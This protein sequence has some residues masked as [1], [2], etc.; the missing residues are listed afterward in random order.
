MEIKTKVNTIKVQQKC[1]TCK[2]G[3]LISNGN[4]LPSNPSIFYHE[5]NQCKNSFTFSKAYP[6]FEYEPITDDTTASENN[7]ST[8]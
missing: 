4:V 1:P 7:N 5:C 2:Q 3:F 6:Y 8:I